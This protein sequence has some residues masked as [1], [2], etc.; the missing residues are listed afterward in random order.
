[1][2]YSRNM[3][4]F[5][6][7]EP[8]VSWFKYHYCMSAC[9]R[10]SYW[11]TFVPCRNLRQAVYVHVGVGNCVEKDE[12]NDHNTNGMA[13]RPAYHTGVDLSKHLPFALF[14]HSCST[15]APHQRSDSIRK[16]CCTR[17]WCLSCD[18][19][20]SLNIFTG[21]V[22]SLL[23]ASEQPASFARNIFYKWESVHLV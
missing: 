11:I 19:N 22:S 21:S 20:T 2:Q 17:C 1:M 15:Y 12:I 8:L 6:D 3:G 13:I 5:I 10:V 23:C 14:L 18:R 16:I 4:T 9:H 7:R